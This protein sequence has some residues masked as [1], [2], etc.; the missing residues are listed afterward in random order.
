MSH[1][2]MATVSSSSGTGTGT[3]STTAHN[4]ERL[5]FETIRTLVD[6]INQHVVGFIEDPQAR[7]RLQLR[8]TSKLKIKK[9]DY[10][11]FSEH[12]VL[13]NLYWGILNLE[14]AIQS[15][16]PEESIT[17]LKSTE[18]MLQVP[19]LLSERGRTAGIRNR[20]LI[21]CSYFYLSLV[22][23]L[24]KDEWQTTLHFLQALLV[25][26]RLVRMEFIPEICESIFLPQYTSENRARGELRGSEVESFDNFSSD[27]M[28]K[29]QARRYK[30]WLMYYQIISYGE[31]TQSR[32]NHQVAPSL[33][34]EPQ[35]YNPAGAHHQS[36]CKES[37]SMPINSTSSKHSNLAED[38]N[39]WTKSHN[40]TQVHPPDYQ[41][42]IIDEMADTAR[43]STL[44]A[45]QTISPPE[46]SARTI[47][48][49]WDEIYNRDTERSLQIKN[50]QDMLEESQ[51]SSSIHSLNDFPEEGDASEAEL[52]DTQSSLRIRKEEEEDTQSETTDWEVQA[53][54]SVSSPACF[55]KASEEASQC[56]MHEDANEG[57]SSYMFSST[58]LSSV[59]DINLSI[60]ELKKMD[61]NSFYNLHGEGR[62]TL[63]ISEHHSFRLFDHLQSK[64]LKGK[65][66]SHV[67]DLK[68]S[69]RHKQESN[70]RESID[71]VSL[72]PGKE[73]QMEIQWISEKRV[74]TLCLSDKIEKCE[75][76][77]DSVELTTMQEAEVKFEQLRNATLDQLLNIISTS[78][79][80]RVIRVV[81]SVLLTMI[82][83][84]KTVIEDIKRKGLRLCNLVTALKCN[85]H[86]AA[87]LI[88]L[89]SPS[90]K[91]TKG[92]ELLPQLLKVACNS[93]SYKDDFIQPAL[94]PREAA[95]LMIEVL[96]TAFDSATNNIHLAAI[97]S[98]Q[99]LS[100][101]AHVARY[102]NIKEISSLAAV[103]VKCMRFD[104]K[105]RS[106]IS[107]CTP[108]DPFVHLLRSRDKQAERAALQFFHEIL[109]IPRSSV[110]SLLN[111]IRQPDSISTMNILMSC[112]QQSEPEY[113]LM[114]ANLLLQL[115]M[116]EDSS[117]KSIFREAA[118]EVVLGSITSEESSNTRILSANILSNLGG[119]YAWTGEPYTVAQ[120][121]TK[122]GL[123]SFHH[124]NMIRNFDWSEQILEDTSIDEWSRKIAR[125]IITKGEPL[126]RALEKGLS[127]KIKSV[128]RDCLIAIAWIGCEIAAKTPQK[129]RYTACEILLSGIEKFLHPGSDLEERLLACLC[130]YNYAS[131]KGMQKLIPFSEGVRESLRR[132]SNISWMAEELL[133]VT[134]YFLQTKSRISCVHTQVL[135]M[136][137]NCNEAVNALIYYKGQLYSGHSNGSIK[138]WDINKQR[139]K[140]VWD[141]KEHHKEVTCFALFEPEGSLL[142]GSSDKTIRVWKMVNQKLECIEVI[143]TTEPIHKIE[144]CGQ[145]IF[146]I[147]ESRGLKVFDGS[148]T[149]KVICKSKQVKCLTVNQRKLYLGCTDSSIQEVD[150]PND[151]HRELKSPAKRW[152]KQNKPANSV[153]VYRDWLYVAS[154]IVEGSNFKEWRRQIEPQMSITVG[155]GE[156]V[157]IMGVVEDF[158]Y[159]TCSSS[160]SILQIW[161]R[162]TQQKVGR[163]SAGSRITSLLT[164]ND[165]VICGTET[166]LIK[167]WIPF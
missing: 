76:D 62:E 70:T 109:C 10:F 60:S 46:D 64:A 93:S 94:T 75:E 55:G 24:Q 112:I 141:V 5:N 69:A 108:M 6:T 106:L 149:A 73:V 90:P 35:T 78:K 162:G 139:A 121:V 144:T 137:Q 42:H 88:Y 155:K 118:M 26:P 165:V 83:E 81:V 148:R 21:C 160:P 25:C 23:N 47:S 45:K 120:L 164:A 159:L 27:E 12:S 74:S 154:S 20:F 110:T 11:E 30:S 100:E 32:R 151:Q 48:V 136:G 67:G 102:S 125:S 145:Q 36:P 85:V 40:G 34:D 72:H 134:D 43:A 53:T 37:S 87:T 143:S 4:H 105:C 122:A 71:A 38:G 50:I 33:G 135:E 161:L 123:K 9:Q 146:L 29:Q 153:V 99:V 28:M 77:D 97:S 96:V 158:I 91:E 132:L 166:G 56:S 86:D 17:R 130:V 66:L 117:D 41:E 18:K 3:T 39:C 80:E 113:R 131:G 92:F 116:M 138:V 107:N 128:S 89:I 13:S 49:N 103:L 54:C 133:N 59:S 52:D 126:F 22:R 15:E 31:S 140:L 129:L 98:S 104:G 68:N 114:A 147:T 2:S 150:V 95:L 51:S 65:T 119:T 57:Y 111:Q 157:K 167:G 115:D 58:S 82:A 152:L 124:K 84:N 61:S 19:A 8:C 101:L 7:K 44:T 79:E 156:K 1:T 163:L 63:K 16:N 127:S 14:S 142:S